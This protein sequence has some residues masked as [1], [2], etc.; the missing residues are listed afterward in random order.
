MWVSIPNFS[1]Y[2]ISDQGEVRRIKRAKGTQCKVLKGP[3]DDR[4]YRV[5][6]LSDKSKRK[7]CSGHSLMGLAFFG[8][9]QPGLEMDH[10]NGN[11]SDN[12]LENLRL[13]TH[14]QNAWNSKPREGSASQYKGVSA[15]PRG[16]WRAA[17][18]HLGTR[19]YIGVYNTEEEAARAYDAAAIELCG[20][21]AYVNFPIGN[22]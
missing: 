1:G 19:R 11:R 4:G 20:E 9:L 16:K 14:A 10:I 12:R 5:Y 7:K 21:F 6:V 22:A 17:I 3:L 18:R 8:G 13:V 15:E 2:E